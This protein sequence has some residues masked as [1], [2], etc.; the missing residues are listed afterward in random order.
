MESFDRRM[1]LHQIEW[2]KA[3]VVSTELGRW[4]GRQHPWIL[5]ESS[6]EEGLWPGIRMESDDSLPAYL[7][8]TGVQ[9]HEGVHNLKS[10]W[11]L[12]A[13]LYFPFRSSLEGKALF[14]AFLKSYVSTEINTLEAIEL[15]YASDGELH[16]SRLL[17]EKGGT[18]GANQTSPDLGL[19]VNEGQGLVLVENKLTE[20]SFYECSAWRH[21]GNSRRHGNPDPDRCNHP[22][23]VA[24]CPAS[25]C[26]QTSWGRRYWDHL[27]PIIDQEALASLPHCPAM[28]HGYQLFRQHA[29]AEGIA[30]SGCYDLVVSVLAVDERNHALDAALKRSGIDGMN[31]W[32]EV[33]Q[34]RARFALFTHQEW[35]AWVKN[36]DANGR[37]RDWLGYVCSR[38][39]FSGQLPAGNTL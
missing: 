22:A 33:F 24:K 11:V 12:C 8:R 19:L 28:R 13:N 31:W 5:P 15:E 30:Q 6:W 38:Y 34:G 23:E 21:K 26:H 25:Q 32:G 4:R 18:R 20:H 3:N 37:W 16:P 14:A 35:V 17:G 27:A 9:K 29:L 1:N 36:H 7:E 39:G 2:R 10:S